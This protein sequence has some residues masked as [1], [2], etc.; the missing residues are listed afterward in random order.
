MIKD[1]F[2]SYYDEQKKKFN[3]FTLRVMWKK[4]G[5]LI[6]KISA[7]VTITLQETHMFEPRWRDIPIYVGVSSRELVDKLDRNCINGKVDEI[8]VIFISI[9]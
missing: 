1:I 9:F 2:Q 8:N 5:V 6:N 7:P 3:S 4:N